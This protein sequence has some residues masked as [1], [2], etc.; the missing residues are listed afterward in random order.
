MRFSPTSNTMGTSTVAVAELATKVVMI[1][2]S[3]TNTSISTNGCR[4]FKPI[5]YSPTKVE[6]PDT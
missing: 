1:V 3:V 5:K 2:A 4:L 6:R